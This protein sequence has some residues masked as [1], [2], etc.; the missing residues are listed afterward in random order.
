MNISEIRDKTK[1]ELA[2]QGRDL[3]MEL[4]NLKLQKASSQLEKP[5]RLR[6]LRRDIA[7]IETQVTQLGR[8]DALGNLA[9]ALEGV[10]DFTVDGVAGALRGLAKGELS[11]KDVLKVCG[12]VFNKQRVRLT[13]REM[14]ELIQ[15]KGR[16][17]AV[18]L[19]KKAP[20]N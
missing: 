4:F 5:V 1:V 8:K 3:R 10:K 19:I 7:R 18:E 2:A 14:A 17:K 6:E 12:S 20:V 9:A 13:V 11:R 15:A 16:E